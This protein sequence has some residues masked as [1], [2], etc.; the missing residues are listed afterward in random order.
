MIGETISGYRILEQLVSGEVGDVFRAEDE[1][2]DL[3]V[4]G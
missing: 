1:E 4:R 2:I 3:E